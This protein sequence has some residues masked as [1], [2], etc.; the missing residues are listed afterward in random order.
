MPLLIWSELDDDRFEIRKVEIFKN[1][2]MTF[3]PGGPDPSTWLA[4]VPIPLSSVISDGAEFTALDIDATQ[5]EVVWQ[6]A[7]QN[8]LWQF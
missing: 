1:G 7:L 5:F 8:G 2:R 4:D 6:E 3:A